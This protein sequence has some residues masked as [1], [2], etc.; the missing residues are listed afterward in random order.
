SLAQ[1]AETFA[2]MPA[3]FTPASYRARNLTSPKSQFF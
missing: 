2:T 3:C 1:S